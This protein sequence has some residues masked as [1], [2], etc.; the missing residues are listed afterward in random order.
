MWTAIVTDK[1]LHRI[2]PL[3]DIMC[4]DRTWELWYFDEDGEFCHTLLSRDGV[5]QGCVMGLFIVC[6]M[7]A[8][9]YS[10]LK[11]KL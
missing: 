9:I 4:T 2:I 3:Y 5:R 10:V 6:A 1:R 7:I 8:S 11:C